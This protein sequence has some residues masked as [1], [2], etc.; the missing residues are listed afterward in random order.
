[1]LLQL[2][3]FILMASSIIFACIS[4]NAS[5]V[6]P[7]ALEGTSQAITLTF[8][9][10]AGYLFFCGL[11]EI[12]KALRLQHGLER[13]LR[14]LLHILMPSVKEETSR[15]AIAL[16]LSMN[17]LGMG[18][19][20]TP[21]GIEAMRR[22]D[23]EAS[24]RPEVRQDMRMLLILNA[25]SLQLLPTTVLTLR[26]AAGSGQVN[27]IV[28]PAFLCTAVSTIVG[29]VLGFACRKWEGRRKTWESL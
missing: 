8:R 21:M 24:L 9:L 15:E 7:A 5:Q 17:V 3:W 22:M 12:C 13:V 11:M 10:G 29:A 26:A 16:N 23:A 1:M 4:G 28:L 2:M 27:A 6:L 20:A 25:T 14:P 18:N 19:A